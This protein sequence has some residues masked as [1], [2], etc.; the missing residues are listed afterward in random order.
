MSTPRPNDKV[1]V[2]LDL[3]PVEIDRLNRLMTMCSLDNR[4]DLFNEAMTLFE[5]A[6]KEVIG[7]NVIASVNRAKKHVQMIQTPAFA[8]AAEYAKDVA[9]AETATTAQPVEARADHVRN[10][11]VLR[12][13]TTTA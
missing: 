7:G 9:S 12:P 1:R 6:I 13:V 2:Q 5:W 8:N 3:S 10:R 4:K 11:R